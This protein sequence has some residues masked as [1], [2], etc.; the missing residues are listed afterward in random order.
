MNDVAHVLASWPW[1]LLL[2]VPQPPFAGLFV[3]D[4]EWC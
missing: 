4:I 2:Q 3:H 1:L